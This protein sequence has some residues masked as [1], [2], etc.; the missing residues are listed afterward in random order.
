[1]GFMDKDRVQNLKSI[2]N[3]IE[4]FFIELKK[5]HD[6]ILEGKLADR[7]TYTAHIF[8]I[9]GERKILFVN[10]QI[11]QPILRIDRKCCYLSKDKEIMQIFVI[12]EQKWISK[13]QALA[14]LLLKKE[15]CVSVCG[16]KI[17]SS[18]W[19]LNLGESCNSD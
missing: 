7:Y 14:R 2:D 12:D 5:E 13:A 3:E 6:I 11:K 4:K 19:E 9:L 18:E 16:I 8:R 17:T 1:M 10:K 15:N